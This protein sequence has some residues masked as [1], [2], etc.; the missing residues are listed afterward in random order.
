MDK[1]NASLLKDFVQI[2]RYRSDLSEAQEGGLSGPFQE[3]AI[4][5]SLV[6]ENNYSLLDLGH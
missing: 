1:L 3:R 2:W 5:R 4:S 6:G